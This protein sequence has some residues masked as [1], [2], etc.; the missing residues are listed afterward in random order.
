VATEVPISD[1]RA[2]LKAWHER[3]LE[4]EDLIV[5]EHGKPVVRVTS[6]RGEA[7]LRELERRGLLTRPQRKP[8]LDEL[9]RFTFTRP[10]EEIIDEMRG[11]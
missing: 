6:P 3:V 2:N 11:E 9:P 8:S 4:G 7:Y 10:S 1:Y 5:T